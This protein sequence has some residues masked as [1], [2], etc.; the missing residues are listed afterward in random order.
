MLR[1]LTTGYWRL[2]AERPRPLLL[3]F[4]LLFGAA[5]LGALWA[6]QD[7]AAALGVVPNQFRQVTQPGHPWHDMTGGEQAQFT[8]SIFTNNIRVT[9]VAFAGGITAG[10]FTAL[11]LVYNGLLLGVIG[12]LMVKAGNGVGF[13]DLVTAHGVLELSC[14]LVAGAAGLRLGWAI[15]EPGRLTR[16]QSLQREA[17]RAVLIAVGTAPWLVIA[18]IVEGNRA[19]LAESGIGAVIGVGA[20]LGALYWG[21]VLWRGGARNEPSTWLGDRP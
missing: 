3:A 21:L 2:I 11:A 10:I 20:G 6:A 13:V 14:I 9:L 16:R 15:V 7:P 18:G 19:N 8:T 1:F 5:A 4:L 17:R 12:G